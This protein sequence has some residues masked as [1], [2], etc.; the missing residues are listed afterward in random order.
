M[1]TWPLLIVLGVVTNASAQTEAPAPSAPPAA[2]PS[3]EDTAKQLS[4]MRDE[5]R[6]TLE[7]LA[8]QEAELQKM[9][10]ELAAKLT[11]P[12]PPP[13]PPPLA[14]T[15]P[16]PQAWYERISI[17]GYTQVRYNAP[18]G[19]Y[20]DKL[21]NEQGDK[22]IG[23]NGGFLIRRARLIL[24]GDISP[25]LSIYLQP[26]F[27]SAIGEQLSVTILRDW[28]ADI[29]LDK[30]REFRFRVGQSKVPYGF[31]NMQSS[32]NRVPLDRNDALNSAVKDER[33][34]GIF[35]YW[36]PAHIRKRFAYLVESGLKGSGDYG[37]IA[38]GIFNGQTANRIELNKFPHAIARVTWPFAIRS[39]L[40][41]LSAG[42]YYGRYTVKLED[43]KD[44]TKF[45]S[46]QADNTF[47]DARAHVS[48]VLYPKP[49]GFTF[50]YNVGIGPQ[51]GVNNPTVVGNRFL[52]G[53]YLT[54]MYKI[55]HPLKTVAMIPYVRGQL[56]DG[57]KKFFNNAPHY[58]IREIEIGLEWQVLKALEVVL[59]Y[60]ISDRTS[61]KYPYNQ[62]YG[63]LTR[64]Q[65]QFNY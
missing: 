50:E 9:K 21:I 4:A 17:R 31:E 27:A 48:A 49:F 20:N 44:G 28:Y 7:R 65:V 43:A 47:H 12:P 14:P 15:Q 63:H 36:A 33:D 58:Q 10:A 34:L 16:K 59:A 26:D 32:S 41:E 6:A 38:L 37:V 19:V 45:T 1:R 23:G 2:P 60:M 62:E 52:H 30:K 8:R 39:Q 5:I 54:L 11:A 57:G 42:G 13:P 29:F 53:G 64:L 25:Y 18:G 51:L 46:T 61:D 22:S 55:D 3:V 40:L 35:F 24:S 56:Y